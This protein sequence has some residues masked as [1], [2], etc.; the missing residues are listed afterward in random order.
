MNND[1][2]NIIDRL[3]T[4]PVGKLL[5]EYSLPAVVGVV[6]MS[7]YNVMDRIF[8]GRGV[9]ADAI[10]GL[11]VT[12]PVMNLSAAIGL[13]V[14]TGAAAR[15]SILLGIGNSK[16]AGQVLGNSL[17]LIIINA[18][19]Y[20]SLFAIY[21]DPI[22]L[23]FGASE[24]TL[25]YA[26]DFM[27]YILPG[28]LIMNLMYGLNNI[29][30][31]SGYPRLA[32]YT[33]FI[34]AGANLILGPLFIF[35]FGLGIK[36][37]A[38]ATDLAMGISL[39][40]VWK[41]FCKPTSIVHFQKGIYRL[42]CHIVISVIAIGA[43]P[44]LVNFMAC[45]TNAMVNNLLW[46]YGGDMA[47]GAVGIFLTYTGVLCMTVVGV[48]QGVQPILGYNYGANHYNRLRRAFWMAAGVGVSLTTL[49]AIVAEAFPQWIAMAFTDD[50]QLIAMTT[51][52]LRYSTLAFMFI[53]FQIVATT[54][55]QSLGFAGKSIF[56]SLV[57]QVVFFVPMLWILPPVYG[58]DGVWLA[59]PS[60][61][62][63]AVLTV[64]LMV[65]YQLR[66]LK[67]METSNQTAS[68]KLGEATL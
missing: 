58:L 33:M 6:V 17:V 57:R 42:H 47:V 21:I 64:V 34:G 25:P 22:L 67:N 46:K 55:F 61:D 27:L 8:I 65:W 63:F 12:F 40:F 37:A 10:A 51:H 52:A 23:L 14:G 41:H 1:H 16:E 28:M 15:I 60:S 53:G 56:V 4:A 44:S 54:L 13:L 32:M 62:V 2:K 7:L 36:G 31:A 68:H 49:G 50:E 48:C 9:G 35:G 39:I 18:I 20:L 5:W 45:A 30:R 19:I 66:K 43:A 11:A 38:I 24:T 26:R 59:F 29:M 3:G